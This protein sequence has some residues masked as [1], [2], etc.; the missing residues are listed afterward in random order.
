MD[1]LASSHV[2]LDESALTG[3]ARPVEH[4]PGDQVRSGS[5]NG[6]GAFELRAVA[7]AGS[8]FRA[9]ELGAGY[10]AGVVSAGVLARLRGI[11]DI[12]LTA[13]E[14]DPQHF[15]F[16]H[17]HFADNGFDPAKHHLKQAAVVVA[18]VAYL[19]A[20]RDDKLPRKPFPAAGKSP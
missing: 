2:V 3:E 9:M 16:L 6:G 15:A 20:M 14:A 1:G 10:G 4:D 19:T 11:T 18:S 5:V 17:E 8:T 7:T 12:T 13:I